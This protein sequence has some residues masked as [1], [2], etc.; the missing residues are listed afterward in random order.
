LEMIIIDQSAGQNFLVR[1]VDRI[2]YDATDF[3]S[4][5]KARNHGVPSCLAKGEI[6]VFVEKMSNRFLESCWRTLVAMLVRMWWAWLGQCL[7]GPVADDQGGDRRACMLG[8]HAAAGD[9]LRFCVWRRKTLSWRAVLFMKSERHRTPSCHA[10]LEWA[11]LPKS[12]VVW[13]VHKGGAI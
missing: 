7:K 1:N 4:L 11:R 12:S 5:P 8:P 13:R 3:K 6:I 2:R 10:V 9:A